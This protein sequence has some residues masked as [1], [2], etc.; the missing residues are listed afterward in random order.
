MDLEGDLARWAAQEAGA[1][2]SAVQATAPVGDGEGG[3]HFA[4][5]IDSQPTAVGVDVESSLIG[6]FLVQGTREHDIWADHE[7]GSTREGAN[8]N[9]RRPL[10]PN[11]LGFLR[12]NGKNG[13]TFAHMVHHPGTG[14]HDFLER[15]IDS[16]GPPSAD[17]LGD[18]IAADWSSG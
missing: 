9:N 1:W 3:G 16:E 10:S 12:F 18:F 8:R 2:Q 5:S 14:P 15:A 6:R 13:L 11:T 4:D 7:L 17:R